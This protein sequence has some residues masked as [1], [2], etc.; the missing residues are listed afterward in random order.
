M[1]DR[2]SALTGLDTD[3][4]FGTDK[5]ALHVC[6]IG[7]LNLHQAAAWPDTLTD[8]GQA[9]ATTVG[10]HSAPGPGRAIT[11]IQGALLRIEPLKW[12]LIDC[13]CPEFEAS[14]GSGLDLSHSRTRI[15]VSGPTAATMLN[16]VL[17]ND[18]R[19]SACPEH[20][21]FSTAMHHVGITVWRNETGFELFIP[22][23]FARSLWELLIETA[24]QFD[25]D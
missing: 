20:S 6:E 12:W 16:R 8:V 21:V 22:R 10:A 1:A 3:L 17:P 24:V 4:S 23:G 11:G 13:H 18:L 19:E 14:I 7:G 25:A 15:R 9:V 2:H 5:N